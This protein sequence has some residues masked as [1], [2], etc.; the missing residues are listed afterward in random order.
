MQGNNLDKIM[1]MLS[2]AFVDELQANTRV[3]IVPIH[4]LGIKQDLPKLYEG[5]PDQTSFQSW[6]AFLLGYFRMHQL[7]VLTEVQETTCL[8]ILGQSLAGNA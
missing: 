5:Q 2:V 1:N 6:L 4:K 8:E 7:D 3:N